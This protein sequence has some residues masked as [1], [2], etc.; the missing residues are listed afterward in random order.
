M[1]TVALPKE[2]SIALKEAISGWREMGLIVDQMQQL[3]RQMI[4]GTLP[5]GHPLPQ[6]THQE[7]TSYKISPIQEGLIRESYQFGLHRYVLQHEAE[8]GGKAWIADRIRKSE[9]P[10]RQRQRAD[11]SDCQ[12]S[13]LLQNPPFSWRSMKHPPSNHSTPCDRIACNRFCIAKDFPGFGIRGFAAEPIVYDRTVSIPARPNP[14]FD[15]TISAGRQPLGRHRGTDSTEFGVSSDFVHDMSSGDF[16]QDVQ[17][18][19]D[20]PD[21]VSSSASCRSCSSCPKEFIPAGHFSRT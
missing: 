4:F 1:R 15:V 6:A 10:Q 5:T 9:M 17:D 13:V 11:A 16:G 8:R 2:Q 14:E 3:S 18:S 7:G 12:Q 21:P 20:G 19:Q